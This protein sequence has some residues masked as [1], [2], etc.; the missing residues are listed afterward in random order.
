LVFCAAKF[1]T[2]RAR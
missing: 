2:S 1:A